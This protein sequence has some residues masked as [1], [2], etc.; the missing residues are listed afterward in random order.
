MCAS[1]VEDWGEGTRAHCWT[2]SGVEELPTLFSVLGEK[3]ENARRT[4]ER[5][6]ISVGDVLV[7]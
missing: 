4:E 6:A 5:W 3:E 2:N 7:G 1:K